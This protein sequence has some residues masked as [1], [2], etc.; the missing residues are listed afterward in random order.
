MAP[1]PLIPGGCGPVGGAALERFAIGGL[2][3][4]KSKPGGG[5][6]VF[7]LALFCAQALD[8]PLEGGFPGPPQLFWGN[9]RMCGCMG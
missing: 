3:P 2:P 1:P 7:T 4:L 8:G 5:A 9:G 6:D